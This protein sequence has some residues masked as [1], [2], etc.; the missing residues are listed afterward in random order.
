MALWSERWQDKRD[1][2]RSDWRVFSLD[3]EDTI[4][5][6]RDI[7]VNTTCLDMD[8][9]LGNPFPPF[10]DQSEMQVLKCAANAL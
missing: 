6:A 9:P 10:A 7:F 1:G 3:L 5:K 4:E 8:R 2:Q